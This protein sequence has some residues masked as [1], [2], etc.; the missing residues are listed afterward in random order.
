M[1]GEVKHFAELDKRY[2]GEMCVVSKKLTVLRALSELAVPE[3]QPNLYKLKLAYRFL[4]LVS[5]KR[6]T[7]REQA[8]DC[9]DND[10]L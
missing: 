1:L 5:R 4:C 6:W 9:H 7:A 10:W 2:G 3:P 8:T